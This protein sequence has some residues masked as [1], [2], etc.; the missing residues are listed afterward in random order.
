MAARPAVAAGMV[1]ASKQGP[2]QPMEEDVFVKFFDKRR[3]YG[4]VVLSSTLAEVFLPGTVLPQGVKVGKGDTLRATLGTEPDGRAC[5]V[6]VSRHT[7]CVVGQHQRPISNAMSQQAE[8]EATAVR[9]LSAQAST[10]VDR[11][12]AWVEDAS[13]AV[14]TP[15]AHDVPHADFAGL[16]DSLNELC[17]LAQQCP[18]N[19]DFSRNVVWQYVQTVERVSPR[20][21]FQC[22]SPPKGLLASFFRRVLASAQEQREPPDK[23]RQLPAE[24]AE[25]ATVA[26]S[27]IGSQQKSQKRKRALSL[28]LSIQQIEALE[29]MTEVAEALFEAAQ[30]ADDN[31]AAAA[32][33]DSDAAHHSS[34]SGSSSSSSSKSL[35]G[36][37]QQSILVQLAQRWRHQVSPPQEGVT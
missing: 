19:R 5:V 37:Q 1:G 21:C 12:M 33:A 29:A 27:P 24:A 11:L 10:A 8:A 13:A 23:G 36:R 22:A 16:A 34:S 6:S 35:S 7:A 17:S 14:P 18:G 26:A 4:F 30:L 15:F 32:A 20:Q 3:N 9:K 25:A 28:D 31:A 2:L